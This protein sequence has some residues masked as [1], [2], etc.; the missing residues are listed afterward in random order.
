[1]FNG[2]KVID[3]H[4]HVSAP[5]SMYTP[6]LA[7]L[8]GHLPLPSLVRVG[9]L[10][11][12]L[13]YDMASLE[14]M[15]EYHLRHIDERRID[16]QLL[17]PRTLLQF[18]WLP[19][20]LI[21]AY[22]QLT[23]D[24][25][26]AQCKLAPDRFLGAAMLP[27]RITEPDAHHMIP[28][29]NRCVL[30]LGFGAAYVSPDPT[31]DRDGPGMNSHYWD[32]LFE[33]AVH[34]DIPLFVHA[35]SSRDPRTEDVFLGYQLGVVAEQFVATES[36]IRG[37][38]FERHPEL[39]MCSAYCGGSPTPYPTSSRGAGADLAGNLWFDTCSYD[40]VFLEAAIRQRGVDNMCFGTEVPSAS[41]PANFEDGTHSD[42]LVPVIDGFDWLSEP[43]KDAIFHDNALRFCPALER[44]VQEPAPPQAT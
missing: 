38:V 12:I 43:E 23:N 41:I 20:H 39:R 5:M 30:E 42:D 29:L 36:L 21:D 33:R 19:T 34:L 37:N 40:P 17:G 28:E 44:F 7:M 11:P 4:G 14:P 27:Q 32:P 15:L 16:V 13:P 2:R 9:P 31:G 3:V 8:G 6:L 22:T 10:P 1:M 25:I 35:S 26:E 24:L 18:G